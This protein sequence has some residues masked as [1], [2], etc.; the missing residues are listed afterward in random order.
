MERK[1]INKKYNIIYA[2]PPWRYWEGGKKNQSRHYSTMK[3]E[4]IK[5]LQIPAKNDCVL[6]LWFTDPMLIHIFD[7][8]K[9]WG[10]EYTGKL[11]TWIKIN[12]KKDSFF[13]G[14]GNRTRANP[15]VCLIATKGNPKINWDKFQ[16]TLFTRIREH[17]RKPDEMRDMIVSLC[18]D[19]PRIELFAREKVE[20]WDAWGNEVDC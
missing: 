8:V 11:I 7:V 5:K 2:D 19:L 14:L 13:F 17:S 6:F 9:E 18:G 10:F 3:L 20:D 4:D 1:E 16:G 12:K 15:E